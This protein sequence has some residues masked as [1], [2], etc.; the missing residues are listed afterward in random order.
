L[1][2]QNFITAQK[3]WQHSFDIQMLLP[4]HAVV[5]FL[6][7]W[8]SNCVGLFCKKLNSTQTTS[9]GF[10][11]RSFKLI[12]WNPLHKNYPLFQP[13]WGS[14][15]EVFKYEIAASKFSRFF[16]Q[17]STVSWKAIHTFNCIRRRKRFSDFQ[18][19]SSFSCD[20]IS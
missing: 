16:M 2:L 3:K 8:N 17:F 11:Y 12:T 13:F 9:Y 1:V 19:H 18:N 6:L 5:K 14:Y 4:F 10:Y 15:L 20:Q 7:C